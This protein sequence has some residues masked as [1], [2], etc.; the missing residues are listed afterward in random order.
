[1]VNIL[2]KIKSAVRSRIHYN[3]FPLILGLLYLIFRAKRKQ[4]IIPVIAPNTNSSMEFISTIGSLYF[5]QNDHKKLC[6]QKMKL[7]LAYLRERYFLS[8]KDLDDSFIEKVVAKSEIPKEVVQKILL[9][10]KNIESSS[11]VSEKTLIEFHLEMDKFYK[12]CK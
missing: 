3:S 5:L 9:Y 10:Y 11:F 2:L 6:I 4:R 8:T 7:F 1:M 12:N